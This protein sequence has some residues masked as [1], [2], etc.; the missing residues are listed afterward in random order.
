MA[1]TEFANL[2]LN[3]RLDSKQRALQEAVLVPVYGELLNWPEYGGL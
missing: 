1:K 2:V 3:V